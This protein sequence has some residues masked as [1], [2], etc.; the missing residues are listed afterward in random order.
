MTRRPTLHDVAARAGVSKSLVSL[1]LQGSTKVAPASRDAILAAAD[2]LGYRPNRMASNLALQRTQTIGVHILDLHNPVF[3]EILDGVQEGV[4]ARD[5]STLLV[6]GNAD[7]VAERTEI[8]R[9]LESRIE[10]LVL[11]AHRLPDDVLADIAR[12]VPTVVVTWRTDGIAGLDSVAGDDLAGARLAVDHLVSLG[13]ARIVHVSGGDNRI[14]RQR[15]AGYERA[16]ADHG[17][18]PVVID[19]AFT[20][21]G[22]Y[23]GANAAV[24]AGAT[25][26]V[27]AND[28]A[29]IGALAALRARGLR[30]PEDV[31]VVGY[32]GMRLLDSLDLTTVA[33]PLAD[34][35]RAAA[36]LL[37]ERID[38][39]GKASTHRLVETRLVARGSSGAAPA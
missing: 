2:E 26:L 32:D 3:A 20:E 31:S 10:G 22:G 14:A 7:P 21:Q 18:A 4:R 25:A 27:V 19:A 35:G 16:M 28:L 37:I 11:I 1:A 8:T 36:D 39:P 34:M 15:R 33:Q 9:L 24:D 30:V 6:T 12:E 23:A 5:Y 13:H 38:S 17:L 29:A